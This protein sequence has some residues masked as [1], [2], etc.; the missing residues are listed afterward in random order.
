MNSP[1]AGVLVRDATV[2]A[3]AQI[4]S[5]ALGQGAALLDMQSGSYYSLNPV[6]AHV[7]T[8]IQT[9][10]PLGD[11]VSSVCETFDV[12]RETCQSDLH[13]LIDELSA[14]GLID[15]SDAAAA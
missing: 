8:M 11:L 2:V 9:P 4:V 15:T 13:R 1:S 5:C 12:T 10:R 14:A 7:W 6:G 3:H